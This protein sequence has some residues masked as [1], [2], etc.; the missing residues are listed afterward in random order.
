VRGE[1]GGAVPDLDE[2]ARL[3]AL[4]AAL[5][6]LRAR[7]LVAAYHDRSDGG[8]WA[9][10]CEMGFAGGLG[11]DITVDSIEDLFAEELGVVI[12]VPV[13]VVA[14][15]GKILSAH[16]LSSLVRQVATTNGDRRVR[17]RLGEP[18]TTS[19]PVLDEPLR[20]LAQAW[21]EVSWAITRLRT[22]PPAPMRNTPPS[23]PRTIP[24]SPWPPPTRRRSGCRSRR[25][26]APPGHG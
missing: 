26:P 22:T 9:T 14:E 11:L 12:E 15:A 6:D 5:S 17:V 10:L 24:D 4:A 20:D 23:A 7:G 8:L 25:S 18:G 16:G 1:F 13:D 3:T 19:E 2:P 21:D